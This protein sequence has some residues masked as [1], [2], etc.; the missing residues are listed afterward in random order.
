[1]L[2]SHFLCPALT[3]FL[4]PVSV[5]VSF[6]VCL[7]FSPSLLW[8]LTHSLPLY[9]LFLV[10]SLCSFPH[11]T[12]VL[13]KSQQNSLGT[14]VEVING[15]LHTWW[16]LESG[17]DFDMLGPFSHPGSFYILKTLC[18]GAHPVWCRT[19]SSNSVLYPL[20]NNIPALTCDNPIISPDTGNCFLG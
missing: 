15:L 1:M 18:P 4:L 10:A 11:V 20:D 5:A 17:V 3:A 13:G 8:F 14:C 7:S 16:F 9:C 6:S 2:D 12:F 19:L